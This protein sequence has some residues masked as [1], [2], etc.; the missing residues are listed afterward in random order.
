[1]RRHRAPPGPSGIAAT[2]P[3]V[4]SVPSRKI[5]TSH[6]P[7]LAY[8][9]HPPRAPFR[10]Q[11]MPIS[12]SASRANQTTLAHLRTLR[13]TLDEARSALMH[14]KD[15]RID[16]DK[17]EPAAR[18]VDDLINLFATGTQDRAQ[19]LAWTNE[20]QRVLD[21]VANPK[22]AATLGVARVEITALLALL[23]A[24][25]PGSAAGH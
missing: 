1:M 14:F 8:D 24:A 12:A 21:T 3:A 15:D 6:P 4:S 18:R 16:R 13:R 20:I 10:A 25:Q 9:P 19:G 5:H 22:S 11:S 23:A 17:L 7:F 2:L